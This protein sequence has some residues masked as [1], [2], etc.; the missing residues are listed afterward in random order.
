MGFMVSVSGYGSRAPNYVHDTVESAITEALR[1][2]KL[3]IGK[4]REIHVLQQV[5]TLPP[6]AADGCLDWSRVVVHDKDIKVT[7][8]FWFDAMSKK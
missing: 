4:G 3:Q 5:F 6:R 2:S 8:G 7:V 1:L